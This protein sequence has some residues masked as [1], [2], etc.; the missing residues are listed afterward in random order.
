[1]KL[2]W[3]VFMLESKF[4]AASLAPNA[5][6]IPLMLEAAAGYQRKAAEFRRE[7]RW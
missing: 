2:R 4:E 6:N 5:P 1:M 3:A 7:T